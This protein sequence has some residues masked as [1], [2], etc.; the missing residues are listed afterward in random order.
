M[1]DRLGFIGLGVM[2]QPM[3]LHLA[4]N[5]P[6]T[7]YNRTPSRADPLLVAGAKWADSPREVGRQSDVIFVMV[8]ND[9]A[10]EAIALGS[11]GLLAGIGAGAL[12]VD[13]STISPTL[14]LSLGREAGRVGGEWVDAPVTGGDVGARARTLTIMAGGSN[15]AVARATP[16]LALTGRLTVH[17]GGAGQGQTLKLVA[18]LVSAI[19]LMAAS[20][21]LR[22]GQA[23]GIDLDIMETVMQNGSAQSFELGKVLERLRSGNFA[24]G[25]SVDNR[26]KDLDLALSVARHAGFS[27]DMTKVA[28]ELYRRHWEAGF[29][30]ED[31]TS[32]IKRWIESE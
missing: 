9:T 14:T 12:I 30:D 24:P 7:V 16:Y 32:Y 22:L 8:K 31:E 28:H 6:L 27:A 20:E 19:N 25:F 10:A 21:G 11:C 5:H 13:H 29:W 1:A 18:N 2:G 17:V 26:Y 15:E 4:A 3:A 23:L